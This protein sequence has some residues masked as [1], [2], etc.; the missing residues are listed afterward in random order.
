MD[1]LLHVACRSVGQGL[2][3]KNN[4]LLLSVLVVSIARCFLYEKMKTDKLHAEPRQ[5]S[6]VQT[7]VQGQVDAD[8]GKWVCQLMVAG[9]ETCCVRAPKLIFHF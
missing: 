8:R 1:G 4:R 5:N 2:Q 3:D 6:S 9:T 7:V